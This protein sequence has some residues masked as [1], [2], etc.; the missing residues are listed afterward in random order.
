MCV[1]AC[2]RGAE[3]ARQVKAMVTTST[4]KLTPPALLRAWLELGYGQG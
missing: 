1:C 4:S 3:G 2:D